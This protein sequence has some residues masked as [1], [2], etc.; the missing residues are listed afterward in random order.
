MLYHIKETNQIINS[1]HIIE[2]RFHPAP[3]PKDLI[4]DGEEVNEYNLQEVL[5]ITVVENQVNQQYRFRGG[6]AYRFWNILIAP[7]TDI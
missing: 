5:V 4:S 3:T 2:A 1:D 6:T 7:A